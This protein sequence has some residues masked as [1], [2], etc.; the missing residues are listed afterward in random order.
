M[1]VPLGRI[2]GGGRPPSPL[3]IRHYNLNVF[4]WPTAKRF[5]DNFMILLKLLQATIVIL[6]M[7]KTHTV[8][9]VT[10]L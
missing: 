9:Y 8:N 3:W 6:V 1:G 7:Y 2:L 10:S 4:N 5:C